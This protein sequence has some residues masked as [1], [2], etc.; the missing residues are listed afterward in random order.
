MMSDVRLRGKLR[1]ELSRKTK[2][3]K[4]YITL[5]STVFLFHST[6]LRLSLSATT[7]KRVS[8]YSWQFLVRG[9][10]RLLGGCHDQ[11][12]ARVVLSL[13]LRSKRGQNRVRLRGSSMRAYFHLCT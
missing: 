2:S 9:S 6:R 8:W 13:I 10:W 11:F 1:N 5:H 7:L 4:V 3:V 12:F